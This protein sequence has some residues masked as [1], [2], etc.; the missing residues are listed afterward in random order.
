MSKISFSKREKK[1]LSCLIVIAILA[2]A[3]V[4]T[5]GPRKEYAKSG[6]I[7]KQARMHAEETRAYRRQIED[8][9]ATAEKLN[10]LFSNQDKGKKFDLWSYIN[11]ALK[12]N[13]LR[14]RQKLTR[15]N[16]R[17]RVMAKNLAMAELTLTG[18]NLK[19]IVDLL[20]T[21]YYDDTLVAVY[22]MKELRPMREQKDGLSC[23]L[24]FVSPK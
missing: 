4:F 9:R 19:E 20:H 2:A 17:N 7:L 14:E 3:Y 10:E 11:E 5:E 21:I 8:Q 13:E 23:Q 1:T 18:V 24:T 16:I 12:K 15:G 22:E 6:R